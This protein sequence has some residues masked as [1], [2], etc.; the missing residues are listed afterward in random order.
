MKTGRF[1][2]FCFMLAVII[3]G[4][5]VG[6]ILFPLFTAFGVGVAA[7]I[8]R[9]PRID[10][11]ALAE[12]LHDLRRMRNPYTHPNLG[13]GP[14]SYMGRM[15]EKAVY[16]PEHLAEQD[17]QLAIQ[18]LVDFLRH[19]SPNWR[20]DNKNFQKKEKTNIWKR[21]YLIIC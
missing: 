8:D 4:G 7:A 11:M 6:W 19:G 16:N 15:K 3:G 13:I 10:P 5:V 18:I 17:A 21:M 2:S 9:K 20:P 1:G 12:R 14:R